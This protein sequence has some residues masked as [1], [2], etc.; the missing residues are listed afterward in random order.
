[1]TACGACVCVVGAA[2]GRMHAMLYACCDGGSEAV[3]PGFR[4]T[5]THTHTHTHTMP[6]AP[7][8]HCALCSWEALPG[9]M[10]SKRGGHSV[11]AV[12]G[13]LYALGGF[14][15]VQAIHTARC[16]TRG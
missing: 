7:L 13:R 5:D 8:P 12:A 1:M 2:S 9:S 4:P 3:L 6:V 10:A 11:A 14:N 15:S 16:L